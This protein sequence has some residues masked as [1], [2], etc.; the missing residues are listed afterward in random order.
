[1]KLDAL[2]HATNLAESSKEECH[3]KGAS[4]DDGDGEENVPYALFLY[5]T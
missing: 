1:M 2:I 5:R 4:N 3:S